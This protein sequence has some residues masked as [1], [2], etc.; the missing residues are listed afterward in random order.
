PFH[1]RAQRSCRRSVDITATGCTRHA[2]V[3]GDRPDAAV[4]ITLGQTV[5][6]GIGIVVIRR[7]RNV[8]HTALAGRE[9]LRETTFLK[10]L[11]NIVRLAGLL[12]L[13][14]PCIITQG[15][16]SAQA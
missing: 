1:L 2:R 12:L 3:I 5:L 8:L 14:V 13:I 15:M 9:G 11:P 7:R 10:L 16:G 4:L 6:L